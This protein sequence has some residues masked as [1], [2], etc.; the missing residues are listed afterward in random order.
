MAEHIDSYEQLIEAIYE[1]PLEQPA[2]RQCLQQLKT[3]FAA[4]SAVLMLRHPSEFDRGV[5]L[6]E[7]MPN[8]EGQLG[9][10]VYGD[11]LYA[12]DPFVNLPPNQV[13]TLDES[14]N[15][16]ELTKTEFYRLGMEPFNIFH[17]LGLDL[18]SGSAID[19]TLRLTRPREAKSFSS[20]DRKR[21]TR[22]VPHLLRA[23]RIHSRIEHMEAEREL[24]ATAVSQF[25]VA[26]LLL[27]EQQQLVSA[28]PMG[29]QLLEEKDGI[30]LSG[31]KL[32]L[33]RRSDSSQLRELVEQAIDARKRGDSVFAQA[34]PVFRP[35]GK[36]QYG[37]VVRPLPL[38]RYSDSEADPVVALFISDPSA[39]LDTPQQSAL[40]QLF[41]LTPAESKLALQLANGLSL[42]EASAKLHI[43]RN[44]G[45]AHLRSIFAKTD[46]AQQTQLVRL[47]LK[48]VA[49]LG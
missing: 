42:D 43:S 23:L 29:E 5:I 16:E 39:E 49:N 44:T 34:M 21:L 36:P 31:N 6:L 17:I 28:N 47:I 18:H 8:L 24:Y 11:Q 14:F 3:A 9:E 38:N 45:R 26:T 22:L 30:R 13:V 10:N 32:A 35:S 33:E 20:D 41:G 7:G 1:A 2:W 12:S 37:L 15:M 25:S 46:V 27:D 19:A 40:C 48:S 4:E